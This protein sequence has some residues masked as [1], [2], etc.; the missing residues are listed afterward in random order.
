MIG[1]AT[2]KCIYTGKEVKWEIVTGEC[3]ERH[4]H[5]VQYL[6][7]LGVQ[8]EAVNFEPTTTSSDTTL[9]YSCDNLPDG[10]E[11]DEE[12]GVISGTYRFVTEVTVNVVVSGELETNNEIVLT[13]T[14]I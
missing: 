7:T 9:R 4:N 1:I 2:G 12:K 13:I 11:I 3:R 10:L 8:G 5:T 6:N 14:G